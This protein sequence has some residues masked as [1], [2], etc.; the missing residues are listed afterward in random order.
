MKQ[1][2][3][4]RESPTAT[5]IRGRLSFADRT[6]YTIERPWI[7]SSPGGKPFY[8]CVPAGDYLLEPFTRPNGDT[9]VSL[10]NHGLGVF[11]HQSE[12]DQAGAGRYLILVHAANWSDQVNGCIAPGTGRGMNNRGPMVTGSRDAMAILMDYIDGEDATLSII[13]ENTYEKIPAASP[14]VTG[15]G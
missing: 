8:S 13:G 2:I 14:A 11:L 7:P 3:L 10:T 6:L 9:V 15:D 12:R 4:S 1:L 5:E